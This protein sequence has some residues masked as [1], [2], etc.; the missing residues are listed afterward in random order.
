MN[1]CLLVMTD[2]RAEYLIRT[3]ASLD[4]MV[5]GAFSRRVIHDDSGDRAY[6]AWLRGEYP[7]Y[8]LVATPARSGFGGAYRSAW[9]YLSSTPEEWAF[10]TEDDFVFTRPVDLAAMVD[11]LTNRAHLVQ[12]ALRRQAWNSDE[13][14]AGGVVERH[15]GAYAAHWDE[16]GRQ[17]LQ[18]RLF[19]TTN[20]S[21]YRMDLCRLGWPEGDRSEGV[22][23]QRLLTEG[24]PGV[25]APAVRFGYWGSRNSGVWVEHIGEERVGSGY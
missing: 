24:A 11:V 15:P 21:L 10:T 19:W 3:L 12:M 23:T 4:A 20:P 2:G 1:T 22:F 17:W 14:A 5:S 16:Q 25:P 18:H 13:I 7:T 6:W 8:D 9:T